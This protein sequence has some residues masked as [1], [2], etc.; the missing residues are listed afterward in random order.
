MA[1]PEEIATMAV[2][3]ASPLSAYTSGTIITVDGGM[4]NK[5]PLF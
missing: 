4:V 2:F 3:L 1:T 5:G